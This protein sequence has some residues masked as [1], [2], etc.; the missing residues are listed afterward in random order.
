MVMHI[1][2]CMQLQLGKIVAIEKTSKHYNI[3][4]SL[5]LVISPQFK[6]PEIE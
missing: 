5:L 4:L 1:Y 3:L 6:L 2:F